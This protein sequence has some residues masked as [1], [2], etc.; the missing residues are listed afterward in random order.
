MHTTYYTVTC[1][2]IFLEPESESTDTTA[3]VFRFVLLYMQLEKRAH[4]G[5]E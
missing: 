5:D 4:G 1:Y 3:K 2:L